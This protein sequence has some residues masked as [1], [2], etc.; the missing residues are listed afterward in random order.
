VSITV[1]H[2]IARQPFDN[3]AALLDPTMTIDN[4][5]K[6]SYLFLLHTCKSCHA[7]INLQLAN[8]LTWLGSLMLWG[9][10]VPI[11]LLYVKLFG[12]KPWVKISSYATII[13]SGIIF[14]IMS[15][16]VTD[17]CTGRIDADFLPNCQRITT[18]A[19]FTLGMVSVITDAIIFVLPLPVILRLHLPLGRRI[20][21][22]FV[23]A[24]GLG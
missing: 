2:L 23:F 11:L 7:D 8:A 1:H 9:C 20:G 3:I 12:V 6:V 17:G 19:G 15:S 14:L 16:L 24:S 18:R 10:K 21:I 5:M 22:T 4:L 13:V